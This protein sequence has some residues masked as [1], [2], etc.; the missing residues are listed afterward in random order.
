VQRLEDRDL[1]RRPARRLERTRR[2]P[3][4]GRLLQVTISS[5]ISSKATKGRRSPIEGRGLFALEAIAKGEVVAIKGG[6]I[7]DTHPISAD[8]ALDKFF[9]VDGVPTWLTQSNIMKMVR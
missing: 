9:R 1:C 7:V 6:H 2:P 3:A 4:A 8:R 5:Y